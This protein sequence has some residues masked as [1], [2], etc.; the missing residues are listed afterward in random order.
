MLAALARA[1]RLPRVA[2][3]GAR[4]RR[5]A[6][7]TRARRRP[8]AAPA[9]TTSSRASSRTSS[10]ATRRCAATT[11]SARAA[12]TPTA[13]RSRSRS[14]SSS[15]S[16]S[17]AR[18]R[19]VRHRRVQ[20]A[21]PRVG[22]RVPRGLERADR[23][24]R[25]LGRPRRR[26]PHARHRPTSSRSGGRCSRSA[27][28]ACSTRATR[29]SRTA[30]AAA[31]RCPATRS[32]SAT[33]TS[34]TRRVYVRFPVAEDGGPVQARRRAARLDDDAVDARRPTPRSPSTPSSPTCARRRHARGACR[35]R[36]G[37]RRARARRGRRRSSTASPAPRSTACAT[38]RRSRSS[39]A[40]S[41]ASAATPCCSATSSP[42]TTAPASCTPRS[43]S[44]RTTSASASSYGLNVVNPVRPDGTY[45]ERIGQYAG[46]F[47]KDA[48]ADLIE[49][50]ERRGRAA[51]RRGATSTP[52][53]TAGAAARRCSTTPSRPGTSRTTT[54]RDRLLAANEAVNWHPEHIKHGR[55]GDW[56]ANNVD[57]ALSRERYWGTPL[58]VWRCEDGHVHVHRLLRRARGALAACALEDPHRPYVDDVTLPVR[59][60]RASAMRRVP[61]VIDVWFDSGRCR[62]RSG[63]RRSRTRSAFEERFPADFICEALDQTRG[64][65]YSL[66]AISTLLFDR[67]PYRNVVCL[68]LIL[69]AEGQKMSKSQGQHRR[70]RGTS[71]TATAPTRSAGTS[72]PPSSR[73]TATASPWTRSARACA[74][75]CVQLWNT[76]A[77]LRPLRARGGAGRRRGRPTS[78]AGCSRGSA[79]RSTRS[80]SAWTTTTPRSPAARSRAFVDDLSNWYV[81][82]SRRRFW[83]GDASRVRARCATCLR[84]RSRSCSRRSRRSSPTRST[85]TST[86]PSRACTSTDW[87]EPPARA[88]RARGGMARRARGGARSGCARA[89]A[90]KV[91]VRQPLH[92][93]VVVAAG[94]ERDGDRA[95]RGRGRATSST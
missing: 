37:A 55:F 31:R 75:S 69:D 21:V 33:R 92:E 23:A 79:R 64:W 85:R 93:A 29:S 16:R 2:C 50:L 83:E 14:S 70:A 82:R 24:H 66:L 13:C 54:L 78:T 44:A 22:L 57:W 95:P 68:G 10:P 5:R 87:P 38:S 27:T 47:V 65:F 94:V 72:S 91:K 74:C 84:D 49:D 42:P 19:G 18:D 58:P 73:G 67:A 12:G 88:T 7:S 32:R 43:P 80:P 76:Y 52:T 46:R 3:A 71:S 53:R 20:R 63:T 8:T 45:D 34:S 48:D 28:R 26:L 86:A 17:K 40:A 51:A 30:R 4:A 81:R 9:R 36:R 62:S 25:L 11:S 6:S 35:A 89:R 41:T 61:E 15:A 1:R 39:P 56:L 60:V 59:R 77:L 90:A